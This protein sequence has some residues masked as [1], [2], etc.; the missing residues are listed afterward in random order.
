MRETVREGSRVAGRDRKKQ[1]AR[2]RY[3]RQ[4]A[5]QTAQRQRT[6]RMKIIGSVVAVVLVVGASAGLATVV[7]GDSKSEKDA[8][9]APPTEQ[10]TPTPEPSVSVKPG[11]C[12]Y[13]PNSGQGA[14]DVG[15]P[16]KKPA[17]KGAT[18]AT[19]K[20]SLGDIVMDL[21]GKKAPCTV[22]SLAFL[23]KKNYFDNTKCHRL[24]TEGIKV[25]QCGDPTGTGGGG[26]AYRF[27][28][29]NTKGAKY[30]R[31]TLAMAHTDQPDSNGSQF[32]IVYGDSQLPPDY[33][34][35]GKVTKSLDVVD[36]VAKAGSDNSGGQGDGV[37][38]KQI[39]IQ[40]VAIS[41]K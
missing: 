27:A 8:A 12:A 31:G 28:N 2:Q 17:Y 14:K 4:M 1:L 36:E 19:L 21:D 6:R 15:T 16:A 7:G 35:F 32:F 41:K 29:E 33:T 23:A 3:E 11:E 22:S 26:P 37:P 39:T 25:L 24:T 5:R 40:D 10:P 38:K 9:A 18:Q 13:L 20:T 34:V 30:G